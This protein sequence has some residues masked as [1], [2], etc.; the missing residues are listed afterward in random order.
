M[1]TITKKPNLQILIL[2]IFYTVG[3]LGLTFNQSRAMFSSLSFFNLMLTLFVYFWG[4]KVSN[5]KLI[6]SFIGV[7]FFGYFIELIGVKTGVLFGEYSYGESLGFKILDIPIIIGVNWFLLAGSSY[8]IV[9]KLNFNSVIK[10]L[11]GA[12][13]MTSL[14]FIIEPVAINLDFWRWN[15][16]DIP[17]QNYVMWFIASFVIHV[18]LNYIKPALDFKISAAILLIQVVFFLSLNLIL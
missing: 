15:S 1:R 9:Q 5:K 6:S 12:F 8:T 3:I 13:I 7:F 4:N 18:F 16:I 2:C 17:I 10:S 14:D 11:I